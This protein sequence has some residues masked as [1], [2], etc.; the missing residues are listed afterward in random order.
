MFSA[1]SNQPHS[2]SFE[3]P[4]CGSNDVGETWSDEPFQ[5]GDGERAI[6]LSAFVPRLHCGSCGLSYTDE[7]AEQRRHEA[8][9]KHLRLLNPSQIAAIRQKY[10]LSQV[11]FAELTGIGRASLARWEAG[12]LLQNASINSL[13]V[14]LSYQENIER[15]RTNQA[16]FAAEAPIDKATRTC[17]FRAVADE[18]IPILRQQSAKFCLQMVH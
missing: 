6:N 5:Y 18:Q 1:E 9:C 12:S 14:L 3:C 4:A 15:L 2:Q 11:A 17:K 10:G 8:V 16:N 13:L 7:R